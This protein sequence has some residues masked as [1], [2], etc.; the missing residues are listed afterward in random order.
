MCSCQGGTCRGSLRRSSPAWQLGAGTTSWWH[1]R[2]QGEMS[3]VCTSSQ[4]T[5]KGMRKSADRHMASAVP[6]VG[7]AGTA[8]NGTSSLNDGT[9]PE[10]PFEPASNGAS[11]PSQAPERGARNGSSAGPVILHKSPGGASNGAAQRTKFS[12]FNPQDSTDSLRPLESL[13]AADLWLDV[14]AAL[15]AIPLEQALMRCSSPLTHAP[16]HAHV[17][18]PGS[19]D[20]HDPCC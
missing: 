4:S 12:H 13:D 10:S 5:C 3:V 11:P 14:G 7:G 15:S 1:M 9:F 2:P 18:V 19:G 20:W 8:Y 6:Y 16:S 17:S